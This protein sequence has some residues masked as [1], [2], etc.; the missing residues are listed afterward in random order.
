MPGP[1]LDA[2]ADHGQASRDTITGTCDAARR[3]LRQLA[4]AGIDLDD[5]TRYLERDGRARFEKS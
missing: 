4:A 3:V 2:F 5:V 1:A